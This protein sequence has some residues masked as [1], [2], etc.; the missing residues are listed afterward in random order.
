MKFQARSQVNVDFCNMKSFLFSPTH[1]K[2]CVFSSHPRCKHHSVTPKLWQRSASEFSRILCLS[3][4]DT[5]RELFSARF[6]SPGDDCRTVLVCSTQTWTDTPH[7]LCDLKHSNQLLIIYFSKSVHNLF[8]LLWG[9][10]RLLLLLA[11]LDW[12]WKRMRQSS[13]WN[14]RLV[15]IWSFL[16]KPPANFFQPLWPASQPVKLQ[17]IQLTA[18]PGLQL[19]KQLRLL[20]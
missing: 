1:C 6:C 17:E 12:R 9:C 10:M 7:S 18:L 3:A 19:I 11:C 14:G 20:R 15:L 2:N 16:R 4:S 13:G 8:L 5:R